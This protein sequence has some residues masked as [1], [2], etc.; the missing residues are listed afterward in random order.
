MIINS[1][2]V[3][4]IITTFLDGSTAEKEE[5]VWPRLLVKVFKRRQGFGIPKDK[6][7]REGKPY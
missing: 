6:E 3:E 4:I 1:R 7:N 2:N 5:L